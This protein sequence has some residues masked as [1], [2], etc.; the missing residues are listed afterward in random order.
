[1]KGWLTAKTFEVG[2]VEG[3][4]QKDIFQKGKK[5]LE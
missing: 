1:M 4:R 5:K 2:G 3:L